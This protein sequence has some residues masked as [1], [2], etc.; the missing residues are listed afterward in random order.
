MWGRCGAGWVWLPTVDTCNVG[1]KLLRGGEPLLY[2]KLVVWSRMLIP[3]QTK[4]Y[5][6][7]KAETRAWICCPEL[8]PGSGALPR[9]SAFGTPFVSRYSV[10]QK[11]FAWRVRSAP[12]PRLTLSLPGFWGGQEWKNAVR[13]RSGALLARLPGRSPAPRTRG[14]AAEESW[15]F[16]S[17]YTSCGAARGFRQRFASGP[18]ALLSALRPRGVPGAGA[19]GRGK[20]AR[21]GACCPPA[22]ALVLWADAGVINALRVTCFL[23]NCQLKKSCLWIQSL[24][25]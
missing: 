19:A 6:C 8:S 10:T 14:G 9:W 16:R 23:I 21:S 15:A 20:A 11:S 22:A 12:V 13:E 25:D 7:L 3:E 4:A 17:L 2:P 24:A 18:P 1:K 5:G